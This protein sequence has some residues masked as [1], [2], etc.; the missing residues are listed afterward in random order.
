MSE[1]FRISAFELG[2]TY[3][4]DAF[5]ERSVERAKE[6]WSRCMAPEGTTAEMQLSMTEASYTQEQLQRA[7]VSTAT[8]TFI[9]NCD[10]KFFLVHAAVVAQPE[11]GECIAFVGRS[12]AGKTTLATALGRHFGYVSD[13]TLAV[14]LPSGQVFAYP[15]PL[16]VLDADATE[17]RAVG[18]DE[19]GLVSVSG[20]LKLKAVFLLDRQ[21]GHKGAPTVS[22]VGIAESIEKLI[23]EVSHLGRRANPLQDV[24]RFLDWGGGI[25]KVTYSE[26]E[27][28]V[29]V[30]ADRF[31][32]EPEQVYLDVLCPEPATLKPGEALIAPHH[33]A[34]LQPQDCAYVGEEFVVFNDNQVRILSQLAAVVWEAAREVTSQGKFLR[35]LVAELNDGSVAEDLMTARIK[36]TAEELQRIGLIQFG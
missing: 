26:A 35:E 32:N 1:P 25:T 27:Q 7:V 18:P 19:L 22:R 17:K 11:T 33:I 8:V 21:P 2:L 36:E 6:I 4:V 23:P 12:G 15:K 9:D 29:D 31:A 34:A 10:D 30:V 13:E 16:L 28:L 14:H 24:L 3:T 20:D 5:D